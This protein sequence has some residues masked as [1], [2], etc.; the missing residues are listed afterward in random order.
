MSKQEFMKV[1]TCVLRV[2][3]HCDGCKQKV[4]KLL[5]K[6]DGVF[7]VAIDSD[8]GKVTVSGSA[9][10]DTLI[11]KLEK[12]GKHA[13]LWGFQKGPAQNQNQFQN[14]QNQFKNLQLDGGKVGKLDRSKSQKGGGGG[15]GGG[16]EQLKGG[17]QHAQ[18]Q[19]QQLQHLQQMVKGSAK[20][21]KFPPKDQKSVKFNMNGHDE[22][23]MSDH[24][25]DDEDF[26]DEFD[27]DDE[28]DDDEDYDDDDDEGLGHGHGNS[29]GPPHGGYN[30]VPN[31]AMPMVMPNK[32][33]HVNGNGPQGPYGK[34]VPMMGNVNGPPYGPKGMID[35][36]AMNDKKSSGSVKK[37]GTVDFPIEMMKGKGNGN[38][39][40][41]NGNGG[42]KSG[43][44]GK[45]G[46]GNS[47][48]GKSKPSGDKNGEKKK[49][50]GLRALFGFGKK[51]S[52]KEGSV[53]KKGGSNNGGGDKKSNNGKGGGGKQEKKKMKNDFD[54]FD[55]DFATANHGKGGGKGG[56]GS[57]AGGGGGGKMGQM[58]EMG[59]GGG[60]G[61]MGRMGP[62]GPVGQN[63]GGRSQMGMG[64]M[65]GSFPMM[66]GNG[67]PAV[68]GLPAQAMMN[69]GYYQGQGMG[70]G[71]GPGPGPINPYNQQQQLQQLQQQQQQQQY[72]AM[73]MNQQRG[74]VGNDMFQPMMY[75]RPQPAVN[76]ASHP[77]SDNY[78]HVFSDENTE[79]CNV[80]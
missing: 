78:T 56:K 26:D 61:V 49:S 11:K 53:F 58:G 52:T 13:E 25:F 22:F 21:M 71:Y 12:N 18:L 66:N 72:M 6:I 40:G 55:I 69:G 79:S 10:P 41:K 67:M 39:E 54:D 63:G 8:Q 64:P 77:V 42:K 9:D 14:L 37:G 16:K 50:G 65:G 80:M 34:M 68:Q 75:A 48:G 3:I 32:V 38:H 44:N 59:R 60:G 74:N 33:M 76:Y 4:K 29:H 51:S 31:K 24:E 70:P 27:D 62:S 1:Q 5:Q 30:N 7:S 20:D 28:Y 17:G 23:D 57:G 73:M 2:N 19:Q 43:G 36:H 35:V 45:G 15:A 46:S 47:K